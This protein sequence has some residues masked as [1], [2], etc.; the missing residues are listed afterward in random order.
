MRLCQLICIALLPLTLGACQSLFKAGGQEPLPSTQQRWE[1]R[2][3][4]CAGSDCPLVNIDLRLLDDLPEL[5]ALIE[6]ELL[7]LTIELPGDPLPA[8]LASYERD[9][10][11]TAK[12][13]WSSYLQAKILEQHDRLVIIELSSYRFTGGAHGIPGRAYLNYDRQLKRVLSLQ[14]MLLPGEEQAFW[15]AAELAHQAWLKANGL[16][17]DPDY[18]ASWPFER[19][20]NIALTFGAVMLK[21]EVARIAPYSSGHPEL[22][23]PYPRLNGILKPF[24][25]P[26]RG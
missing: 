20:D 25:F 22:R 24:Y 11:A 13:G 1:H 5:N 16:D 9:F 10:L 8:S 19:T 18:Q 21:Y 4:G 14:D 3:P 17:Q 12:P 2:A 7:G 15:Q 6:R 26:G 23:I